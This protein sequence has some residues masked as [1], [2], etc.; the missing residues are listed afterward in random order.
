MRTGTLAF[1]ANMAQL[2]R[3]QTEED[4]LSWTI[5]SSHFDVLADLESKGI[6]CIDLWD[7]VGSDELMGFGARAWDVCAKLGA[8]MQSRFMYSGVDLAERCCCDLF[9]PLDAIYCVT[10]AVSG[11]LAA[12]RPA[13]VIHFAEMQSADFLNLPSPPPD[14]F[15]ACVSKCAAREGLR[16]RTLKLEC[17]PASPSLFKPR[18]KKIGDCSQLEKL[19]GR[20][21]VVSFCE[22]LGCDEQEYLLKSVGPDRGWLVASSDEPRSVRPYL[23]LK[24]LRWLPFDTMETVAHVALFEKECVSAICGLGSEELELFS[25]E[26]F[27]FLWRGFADL[28]AEA[29]RECALGGFVAGALAPRVVVIG[30]DLGGAARCLVEGFRSRGVDVIAVDHIGLCPSFDAMLNQGARAH[31]AVWGEFDRTCQVSHRGPGCRVEVIGSMRR[32]FAS[33][34]GDVPVSSSSG[35]RPRIVFMTSVTSVGE[36]MYAWA[37]PGDVRRTWQKLLPWLITRQGWDVVVKAHPRY[38]H[39]AFYEKLL[40]G[41]GAGSC[42]SLAR[43]EEV[44]PGADVAVLMNVPSTVVV[45]AIQA[46]VPVIYLRDSVFGKYTSPVELGGAVVCSTAGEFEA[47][48]ERL[49]TD[50]LYRAAICGRQKEFLKRAL[51]ATGAESATRMLRLVENVAGQSSAAKSELSPARWI[52][53]LLAVLNYFMVG[54]VNSTGFAERLAALKQEAVCVSFDTVENLQVDRIGACCLKV[55]TWGEWSCAHPPFKPRVLWMILRFLPKDIRP[56]W[57]DVR[58]HMVQAFVDEAATGRGNVVRRFCCRM[59]SLLLAPGRLLP[60]RKDA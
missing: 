46:D 36:R 50:K 11:V 42:L 32:D 44:L 4:F 60:G 53:D 12:V 43:A 59:I 23:S 18:S 51:A 15:N 5:A 7:Y 31:I 34:K 29:V 1:A 28:L 58:A 17:P 52:V 20:V 24:Y 19:P 9:W 13:T 25:G 16:V 22:Q 37:K 35:R 45:H 54:A 27:S 8:A 49:M 48:V 2:S 57:R 3:L 30:Y 47:E 39:Y 21:D 6:A 33:C 10:A 38:D 55:A 26:W 56:S 41:S 40:A 14:I